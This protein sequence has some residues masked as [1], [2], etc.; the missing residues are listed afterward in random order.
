MKTFT[1]SDVEACQDGLLRIRSIE[2]EDLLNE[3]L[4]WQAMGLQQTAS[5]YGS[6]LVTPYKLMFN[7]RKLRVYAICWSNCASHFI[8]SKQRRI[9]LNLG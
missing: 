4:D 3:P 1:D 9:F 5:G 8:R 7:G 2:R 6:N